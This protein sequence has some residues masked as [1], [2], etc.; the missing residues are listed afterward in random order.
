MLSLRWI[1][2]AP[3]AALPEKALLQRKDLL[4]KYPKYSLLSS[5]SAKIRKKLEELP[6]QTEDQKTIEQRKTLT[7]QF[8]KASALQ[9]MA[10]REMSVRREA[11]EFVFPP[12]R[13]A[14]EV[15]A[16]IKKGQVALCF[17][18]TSRYVYAFM[19]TDQNYTHWRLDQPLKITK[20]MGQMFRSLSL[21]NQNHPLNL[22]QI[23]SN[24]WMPHADQ[25][26]QLLTKGSNAEFWDR[27][28]ELIVV[29]DGLLWYVPFEALQVKDAQG[30]LKP[31]I[32]KVRIRYLPTM[33]LIVPDARTQKPNLRT[34]VVAGKL[35]PGEDEQ[36]GT[37]AVEALSEFLP[38]LTIL[39][40][41]LIGPSNLQVSRWDQLIVL[42]DI[43]GASRGPFQWA[44]LQVDAG[45]VGSTLSS[46]FTLPWGGPD[47]VLLPGFHT[48]AED[49][50]KRAGSGHE[51]FLTICGL[52][53]TGTRTILISRWRPAGQ[54]SHD[55]LREFM[56]ELPHT[57]P[58][59]AWQRSVQL[60][61]NSSLEPEREPR[62]KLPADAPELKGDHPFLWGAYLLVDH[63]APP[64]TDKPN[65]AQPAVIIQGGANP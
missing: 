47:R 26:L 19:F 50:L 24:E 3:E 55:L 43:E 37:D 11:T 6:A 8:S 22:E 65:A 2:E 53:S 4:L 40:K 51:I 12:L 54:M 27:Y 39:K 41:P 1:L 28:D 48:A 59:N 58:A 20:L 61:M 38:D 25:L 32:S 31:L 9:E 45:K 49:S 36:I 16:S 18:A 57:S 62:L 30:S 46:W 23:N 7:L 15:K 14:T 5:A 13:T 44:P 17:F 56:Q 35:Y 29:P 34:L 33:G 52:M 64:K 60:G 42:D 10:L 63:A 21:F